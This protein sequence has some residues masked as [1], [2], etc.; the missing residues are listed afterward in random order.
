VRRNYLLIV[1]II[2]VGVSLSVSAFLVL[3]NWEYKKAN[4]S[5]ENNANHRYES[6][7]KELQIDLTSVESL[8]ALYTGVPDVTRSQ[9]GEFAR[10]LLS[11]HPSI[12]ALEWIPRIPAERRAT[13]EE[14]AKGDGFPAFQITERDAQGRV[15]RAA[16]R[17]EYFPVYFVEPYRGNEAALGFDL[18]SNE[19]RKSAMETARDAGT[20]AASGRI[21]LVQEKAD[22]YGCLLF[23]PVYRRGAPTDTLEE[24][25]ENLRGFVLGVLRIGDIMERAIAPTPPIGMPF[26]VYDTAAA[27]EPAFLYHH[28]S[29]RLKRAVPPGNGNQSGSDP[30]FQY[31][32]HMNVANR[33]WMVVF[34]VDREHPLLGGSWQPW[35]AF[36]VG[37]LLTGV[38]VTY[39]FMIMR[40]I[41]SLSTINSRLIDEVDERKR[42]EEALKKSEA[43]LRSVFSA[44]P[45]GFALLGFDRD[46]EWMSD[47]MIALTWYTLEEAKTRS[48]REL[49]E[50]DDE[51]LRVGQIVYQAVRKGVVGTVE[52]RWVRKDGEVLDVHLGAAAIDLN[53][54]SSR[55]VFTATDITM[56]KRAETELR[57]SEARFRALFN[58]SPVALV[59]MDGSAVREE[60]A[61]LRSSG[62]TDLSKYLDDHTDKARQLMSLVK[63]LHVNKA[64]L[65][66]YE[67]SDEENY[68]KAFEKLI[69]RMPNGLLRDD[70]L[71]IAEMDSDLEREYISVTTRGREIYL[72]SRWTVTPGYE[73]S[74]GKI[75]VSFTDITRRKETEDALRESQLQLSDAAD[76]AHIAYWEADPESEEFIFNDPFYALF[77]TTAEREGGYRMALND[78]PTRFVHP[79]DLERYYRH[80]KKTDA[81]LPDLVQLGH[82][83]VRRDGEV[84]HILNRARFVKDATGRITKIYGINQDITERKLAEERLQELLSELEL[85]NRELE[86]AYADLKT[87]H[88][89]ILQQEKMASIG[90]LAAGVAHEINNPMG[91]II[92][93]LNSLQKYTERLHQYVSIQSDAI[94]ALSQ[95]G[96]G[97]TESTLARTAES[98][99]SLKIDYILDDSESLVKESLEGADRVKRIVQDLKSFSRV[100]GTEI[101]PTDINKVLESTINIVWNELKHKATLKKE[102]GDVPPVPG[103]HGQLSQVFMNIFVNAV[104][105]IPDHGEI[106][107][108]TWADGSRIHVAISDTGCGIPEDQ[109]SRLFEPFYTTKEIGQGTGLGLSI[110]YDIVKK[111]HGEIEARSTV[112]QGTTFTVTF[113]LEVV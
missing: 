50:T 61:A 21:K 78:Y 87:S 73:E 71:T 75:L 43:T 27:G 16:T 56:Q 81:D 8:R 54:P 90:V 4:I 13:Y 62:V 103:N 25:R 95:H 63:L 112:G 102:Y 39:A 45:I 84:R 67:A 110:A 29:R 30:R 108:R 31:T 26:T 88:R 35:A 104:Q 6:L 51:F 97:A 2:L 46:I 105:A 70:V 86:A 42:A 79:D 94:E 107:V 19:A 68:K 74:H 113:P 59:E 10:Y 96:N 53:D 7:V 58:D 66:L 64:T 101:A 9:F 82:R 1:V 57:E 38:A 12:Q 80:V 33:E 40:H 32:R 48:L 55:V 100:D 47:G 5:F 28:S 111:H 65:R 34:T 15:T 91:F 69:T 37:L 77:G 83:I 109:M 93:N 18:A 36:L 11:M 24:R 98:R 52:T 92:S 44:S 3:N 76:L 60:L 20:I 72:A 49:Y 22:Q 17:T 23:I 41:G 14:R 99:R 106:A 85:K 89:Q